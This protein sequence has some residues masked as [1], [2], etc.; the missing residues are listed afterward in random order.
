MEH[1]SIWELCLGY[2]DGGSFARGPSGYERK[3]LGT[4]FSLHGAHLGNLEWTLLP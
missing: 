3:A 2:W 4:G 1:L